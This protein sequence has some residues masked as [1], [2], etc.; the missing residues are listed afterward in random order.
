MAVAA[1]ACGATSWYEVR[2]FCEQHEEWFASFLDIAHGIPSHDTFNRVFAIIDPVALEKCFCDWVQESIELKKGS[3]VCIDGKTIRG[4][5]EYGEKSF[6]HMVSAWCS[7]EGISLGQIKVDDKTGAC[8]FRDGL[9]AWSHRRTHLQGVQG[10]ILS[11]R[12]VELGRH[13]L[14]YSLGKHQNYQKDRRGN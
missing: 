14:A 3:T 13:S 10:F 7:E 2:Y 12:R 8:I 6:V 1:A 11:A 5:G 4:C 9:R